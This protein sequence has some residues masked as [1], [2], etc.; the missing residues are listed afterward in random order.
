[1]GLGDSDGIVRFLRVWNPFFSRATAKSR[2]GTSFPR[3]ISLKVVC[4]SRKKKVTMLAG[5]R[6]KK[7]GIEKMGIQFGGRMEEEARPILKGRETEYSWAWG[8]LLQL[9][10][11]TPEYFGATTM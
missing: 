2:G 10:P 8:F 5:E 3:N 7:A 6:K 11:A 1:M 4:S 9:A